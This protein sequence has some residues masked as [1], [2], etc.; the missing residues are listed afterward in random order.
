MPCRA[1]ALQAVSSLFVN[2]PKYRA[3]PS[4]LNAITNLQLACFAS[5]GF[6]GL[7][8]KSPLGLS[9]TLGYALGSPYGIPHGVTST[10]TLGHVVK[11][12][13]EESPENAAQVAR[14]LT[15]VGESRSGDDVADAKRVGDRIS[16]LVVDLGIKK[17]LKDYGVG[18]DQVPIIVERAS[19]LKEGPMFEKIAELVRGLY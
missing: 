5:L 15:S 12:K 2:L 4:D 7:N 14:L 8:V 6:L 18:E 19:G 1:L 10:L 16:K 11:L 9:H 13:A 17:T 3:S